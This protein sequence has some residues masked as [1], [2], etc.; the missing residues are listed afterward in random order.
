MFYSYSTYSFVCV[1]DI[2]RDSVA[3][4]LSRHRYCQLKMPNS[5]VKI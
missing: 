4:L 5:K 1:F 3:G 2:L